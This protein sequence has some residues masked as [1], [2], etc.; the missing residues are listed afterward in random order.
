MIIR[1]EKEPHARKHKMSFNWDSEFWWFI[2]IT[3]I[4]RVPKVISFVG[5]AGASDLSL[6]HANVIVSAC[7]ELNGILVRND[8]QIQ[9]HTVRKILVGTIRAPNRSSTFRACTEIR[10]S[11]IGRDWLDR[12][13]RGCQF[14]P[15]HF[16]RTFL[17]V[18]RYEKVAW[19]E[20]RRCA[21]GKNY[22]NEISTVCEN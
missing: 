12:H 3:F 20:F 6:C 17:C 16:Y 21:I 13:G 10:K 8:E 15:V 9:L 2:N 1:S 5:A 19:N 4:Q 14:R 7:S 22:G 18:R 11:R